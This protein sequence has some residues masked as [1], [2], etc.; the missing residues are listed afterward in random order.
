[1]ARHLQKIT[2]GWRYYRAVPRD[3][4]PI[5]GVTAWSE[6]LGKRYS[7]ADAERFARDTDIEHDATITRLRK[8]SE[9]DRAKIVAKG[10][11]KKTA[12]E[13]DLLGLLARAIERDVATFDPTVTD[14]Q[15]QIM[16]TITRGKWQPTPA[17]LKALEAQRALA[18][19]NAT[20]DLAAL[21]AEVAEREALPGDMT[22]REDRGLGSLLALSK[23]NVAKGK[24]R[25]RTYLTR[26]IG[27]LGGDREPRAIRQLD[28]VAGATP[29]MPQA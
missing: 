20:K 19:Y 12:A 15:A 8:L 3:L 2:N 13:G 6:Y 11:L 17:N 29:C 23:S 7:E 22:L 18:N 26:F 16:T 14:A 28:V 5:V 4:R 27:H 24:Q 10:G 9:Q 1:M 21:K 25:T